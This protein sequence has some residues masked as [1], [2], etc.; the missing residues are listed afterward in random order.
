MVLGLFLALAQTVC[1]AWAS[2]VLRQLSAEH[3][4]TLLNGLRSLVGLVFVLP[5]VWI[6]GQEAGF[7]ALDTRNLIYIV[8][9]SLAGGVIGDG[10][11]IA[12]LDMLGVSRA[13]PIVN[14]FPIFTLLLSAL[15]L[16]DHITWLVVVGIVLV[17]VGAYLVTRPSTPS[18]D[19]HAPPPPKRLALGVALAVLVAVL[20]AAAAVATTVGLQQV[21]PLAVTSI[22]LA[23]VAGMSLAA[24]G[25][26][27]KLGEVA[28]F[29]G[30]KLG[31]LLW[32]GI[33]GSLGSATL[34]MIALSLAGPSRVT[35][36]NATLPIFGAML[37]YLL[38]RERLS[39]TMWAG[40]LLT[41]AGMILVV[42]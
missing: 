22:R 20:W 14:S 27:G 33:L 42:I 35:T 37:G 32:A 26:R 19:P 38:Y 25:V 13:L 21:T 40:T 6:T 34:F 31:A 36:V 4:A 9:A 3:D 5:L 8:G 39:R 15:F 7:Q 10:L 28:Q 16:D 17:L 2:I 29:R 30:K 41:V 23:L 18:D 11:Y 12:V 1:W 24:V